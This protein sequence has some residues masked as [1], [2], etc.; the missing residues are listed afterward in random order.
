[1]L[2]ALILFEENVSLYESQHCGSSSFRESTE[3]SIKR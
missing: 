2:N 1:M 3:G